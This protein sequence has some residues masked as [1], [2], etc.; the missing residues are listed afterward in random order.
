M[1]HI[2]LN[3]ALL[4][5]WIGIMFL[6][7]R[8]KLTKSRLGAGLIGLVVGVLALFSD[9]LV[10]FFLLTPMGFKSTDWSYK[11][12]AAPVLEE[13]LKFLFIFLIAWKCK[14][15]SP[16]IMVFGGSTGI[17]FAFLENFLGASNTRAMLFR[18][19]VPMPFHIATTLFYSFVISNFLTQKRSIAWMIALFLM[20]IVIHGMLNYILLLVGVG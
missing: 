17:G 15:I 14:T 3:C 10:Y 7:L 19:F 8:F 11:V 13:S 16:E 20:T 12:I 6:Y 1:F 18:G 4:I 9:G 2:L 5:F